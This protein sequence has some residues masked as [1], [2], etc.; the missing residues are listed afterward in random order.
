PGS[1]EDAQP[2]Y[3]NHPFGIGMV[4]NGNI[5]NYYD[6][7]R[8]LEQ[9]AFRQLTSFSDVEPI[10]N[11]LAGSLARNPSRFGP[12]AVFRAVAGVFRRVRG[13]YSVVALI[14]GRGLLAFRD[15]YGIKPL[16]F[17]RRGRDCCFASES[18]A[19][20]RL[21][22][23]KYRDVAPGEAV[24]VDSRRR[25]HTRQVARGRHHPCIF[26]YV[27]FARPDSVLDGIEVYEARLRLGAEL[28]REV[29]RQG[30]RPDVVVPVP[31]TAR[32]AANSLAREL[33]VELREG[34]IKNR[35]IART[36]I[37]PGSRDRTLS[38]RQKLNPVRSQIRGRDVMLVDDSIVRG[39]TSK[40]I[41]AMVRDA[42]A[43]KVYLGITA[44][45]LR[46]PCVYGIDMMTRGE[47]IARRKPVRQI[48]REIGADA[49]VYQTFEGLVR[50][51]PGAG[52]PR[53]FC[54]AC[55]TGRYPTGIDRRG[56]MAL[57]KERQSWTASN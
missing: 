27:Y 54:T 33:G 35:Y 8:E 41:V 3:V 32:A 25:V 36:F 56:L 31:D 18:V 1:D 14:H 29:A 24:W 43:R 7:R 53:D 5:T 19:F 57:E 2:F 6:L 17:A 45:P 11:L 51:V 28:A 13:A 46:H 21:G 22:F 15:P 44:P 55:F 49:L 37:M 26:E 38:V 23:A 52:A 40:E 48:A 20:D 42:G 12:D 10:L 50:A 34:L 16:A 39:T 9:R 47:F 4:H 30:I